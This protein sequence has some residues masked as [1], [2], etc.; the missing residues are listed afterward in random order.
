VDDVGQQTGI[1]GPLD[2]QHALAALASRQHG[3]FSL[4]QLKELG[5]SASAARKRAATGRLHRVYRGVYALAPAELLTRDGRFMAA[6]LACGPGAVLS[7][8]SA[9]ALHGLR[10]TDRAGIDVTVPGR[11]RRSYAGID[12]HRSLTLTAADTTIVNGIPCTTIARTL[13]DLADVVPTRGVERACEQAEVLEVFDFGALQDQVHRNRYGHAAPRVREF[14]AQRQPGAAP[15]ESDL[16]EGFLALVRAAGFSAPERQVYIAPDDG[17]RAIRVDFAWRAER[18]ALE[19]DGRKYHRT[20]RAFE[21]D[22]R[23]D[24]RLTLAGWRTVRVTWRQIKDTPAVVAQLV[25]D[26]LAQA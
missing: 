11:A 1:Y 5:L 18:L 4:A 16:E 21:T 2:T 19:T 12:V 13:L 17:E 20:H 14:L 26:L 7:H 22:R 10:A 15:T 3:V 6:V 8:R 23:R 9:A 24:Q 25:A